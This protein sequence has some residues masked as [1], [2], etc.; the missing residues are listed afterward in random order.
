MVNL[1]LKINSTG[2]YTNLLNFVTFQLS[3]DLIEQWIR[4]NPKASICTAEGV[5]EFKN[6][7]NFQD[8]HGFPDFRKVI[9]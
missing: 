6:V 7:A 4:K 5:E 8:Y 1:E 9:N 3:F 2:A